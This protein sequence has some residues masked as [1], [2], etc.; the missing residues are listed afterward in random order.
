M[1]GQ[2]KK[3]AVSADQHRLCP[4]CPVSKE[5]DPCLDHDL[6]L[7]RSILVQEVAGAQGPRKG[8]ERR[9]MKLD[10][11]PLQVE[12]LEVAL[13]VGGR[14]RTHQGCIVIISIIFFMN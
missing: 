3:P 14:R 5:E 8:S 13:A 11:D 4:D 9:S 6:L 12:D 1:S 10:Q 7:Q 2:A